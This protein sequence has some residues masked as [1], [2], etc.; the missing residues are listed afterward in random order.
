MEALRVIAQRKVKN[1][2]VSNE[3][4]NFNLLERLHEM[5]SEI[6]EQRL[7]LMELEE[8]NGAITQENIWMKEEIHDLRVQICELEQM[9]YGHEIR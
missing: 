5:G 1:N 7:M 2:S 3:G 6:Q 4:E 9:I 8:V